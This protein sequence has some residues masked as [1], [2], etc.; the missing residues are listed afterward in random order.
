MRRRR[1]IA[2]IQMACRRGCGKTVTTL[3]RLIHSS[4]SD[5]AKYHG[6]CSACMGEDEQNELLHRTARRIASGQQ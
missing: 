6:I 1:K 3:S 5:Y 4:Q 2:I